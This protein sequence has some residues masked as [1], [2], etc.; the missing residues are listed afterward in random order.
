MPADY[1]YANRDDTRRVRVFKHL[2]G[3]GW[4]FDVFRRNALGGGWTVQ[5]AYVTAHGESPEHTRASALAFADDVV[6]ELKPIKVETVTEGWPERE[7]L[8]PTPDAHIEIK[9]GQIWRQG[10]RRL[11]VDWVEPHWN[12]ERF[13][14]L[15]NEIGCHFIDSSG[16]ETGTMII[17]RRSAR[18]RYAEQRFREKY[19]FV[20]EPRS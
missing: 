19:R 11:L 20:S 15:G 2:S 6:G 5:A 10:K 13:P 3:E 7:P 8:K 4:D 9:A 14:D 18:Q 17:G 16:R 1:V 12:R